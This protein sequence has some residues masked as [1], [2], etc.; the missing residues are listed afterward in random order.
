MVNF[1]WNG[2]LEARPRL[3]AFMVWPVE[4]TTCEIGVEAEPQIAIAFQGSALERGETPW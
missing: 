1:R 3:D 2:E 4:I